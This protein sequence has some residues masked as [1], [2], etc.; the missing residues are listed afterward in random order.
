MSSIKKSCLI[1]G[2]ALIL[3]LTACS[4]GAPEGQGIRGLVL[5]GPNCPV[6]QED[7]PCP[8]TPYEVQLAVT[9]LAGTQVIKTFWSKADGTFEVT[10][11]VGE[12]A[13]HS[14][15]QGGLP[16]CASDQP[17][18]VSAGAMTETIVSCDTGIR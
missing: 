13:I 10:L 17:V 18:V 12:Y 6:M 9:N 8:D 2:L 7:V 11:P 4:G 3:L 16:Y 14:I 1:A 5:L 15:E